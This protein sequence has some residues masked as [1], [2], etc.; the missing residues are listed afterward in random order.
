MAPL[1]SNPDAWIDILE[2]NTGSIRDLP[3][4]IQENVREH[5]TKECLLSEETVNVRLIVASNLLK[6]A[7]GGTTQIKNMIISYQLFSHQT[8]QQECFSS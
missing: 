1:S 8:Y 5:I 7:F 6:A 4:D 3:A 2:F